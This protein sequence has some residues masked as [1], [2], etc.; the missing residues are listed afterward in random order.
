MVCVCILYCIVS[1]RTI[2][3]LPSN[4]Q[5]FDVIFVVVLT[6]VAMPIM[7]VPVTGCGCVDC[8]CVRICIVN[9][10]VTDCWFWSNLGHGNFYLY[11]IGTMIS[12]DQ[13]DHWKSIGW[14]GNGKVLLMVS[15]TVTVTVRWITQVHVRLFFQKLQSRHVFITLHPTTPCQSTRTRGKANPGAGNGNCGMSG[16]HTCTGE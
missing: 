12:A 13:Q 14:F 1:Q 7:P 9:N 3:S 2:S 10:Q 6:V 5:N 11:C 4:M 8:L 16:M 15:S